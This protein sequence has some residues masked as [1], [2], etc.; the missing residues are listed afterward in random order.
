M[1]I[2]KELRKL[3]NI[4]VSLLGQVIQRELG[5]K[6]YQRIESLRSGMAMLRDIS[7]DQAFL[8]LKDHFKDLESLT[9]KEHHDIAHAFTLMLELM[10]TCEN[11]YRS[12]RVSLK[13]SS[14]FVAEGPQL[15]ALIY[16]L[17][18]H[19]TEA[20]SPQNIAVF[21]QIQSLLI[22]VL[23][24]RLADHSVEF[25]A[26][27]SD[28][29]THLLEIAWRTPVIRDRS[30]KVKDEAE[31]IYSLLFRDDV[32]FALIDNDHQQIPFF[33][34]SW[35]GGDKDGHPGVDEKTMLQSLT[36]SR[37]EIL[38]IVSHE[39]LSIR[40]T[41]S[42]FPSKNLQIR[43]S[44]IEKILHQLRKIQT[45]DA[46]KVE[47]F[48]KSM[49]LF[50]K[51]YK[52]SIG[53]LHPQFQRLSQILKTFPAL[54]VPLE[55][56]ESSDVLMTA[57]KDRKKLAI[58]RMLVT[59]EKISRGSDPRWYARG[60]I[61]SMAESI[62][63]IRAASAFQKSI[64]KDIP[65]S[66]IPLFENSKALAESDKIMTQMTQDSEIKKAAVKNWN[67]LLEMMVG[68]SD[69]AKEA[70][71]L[72]SRLAIS[73][74]LPKLEKVCQD[75]GLTAVFFHGSGGSIDR[76]GGSIEDQTAWWPKSALL[77]YKVTV[78][79][80]MVERSLATP[81]IAR[82][83][84]EKIAAC[85][86]AGLKKEPVA[87]AKRAIMNSF[88]KK[89]SSKYRERIASL[90]F[91]HMVESATPYS[92]LNV[93]KIGS[94]PSKRTKEISV[95]GLRAIPWVLCWTQT[96]VLFPTWWGVGST[97][98][99][100]NSEEKNSLQQAFK[101]DP[102]F[103]SYIKALGFTLAKI[104]LSVWQLYLAKSDL[105]AEAIATATK[106]FRSEYE[107]TLKCFN[108]IC[109]QT[110][111]LW[112]R[113]WLGESILLRSA[114]IHPLNM[115]QILAKQKKDLHLLRLTVTGISSGMQT[116]G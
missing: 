47:S 68:Y 14:D 73:E 6:S 51:E 77:R 25:T 27:E 38:R 28:D 91:L 82:R 64:W 8:K 54:V 93:L 36:L 109:G 78:Q 18:A 10:N 67:R 92:Y 81:A 80:E 53:A 74:A 41:L 11:A 88:A 107:K 45:G 71:V 20:R 62:E 35:V 19:P 99:E 56:R 105:S 34:R 13:H 98:A 31:H 16:V 112:F 49:A 30:P 46:K 106:D 48:K 116:T 70:G 39:L 4:S 75:A 32:L 101:N 85:A 83:Q 94:R 57:L 114:M 12:H 23:N 113:P 44:E 7:F 102:V 55:L 103:T 59:I 50:K 3:V 1:E 86:T 90:E 22:Q 79:G 95:K 72:A 66:V 9:T 89:I 87:I 76:G 108:E 52:E 17:T 115:L 97:W 43:I 96:R 69:S 61:I 2:P 58:H 29:L 42:L 24:H 104:E 37:A 84:I 65:I 15:E 63:H 21:H 5:K 26:K 40:K 60:F 33:I 100:M 111:L 110:D